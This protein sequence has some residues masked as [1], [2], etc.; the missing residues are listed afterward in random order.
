LVLF[1]GVF[2]RFILRRQMKLA[3]SSKEVV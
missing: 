3:D 1:E 2:I